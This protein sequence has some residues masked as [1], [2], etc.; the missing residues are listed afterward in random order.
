MFQL[1][2]IIQSKLRHYFCRLNFQSLFFYSMPVVSV[3]QCRSHSNIVLHNMGI[4]SPAFLPSYKTLD[5]ISKAIRDSGLEFSNLIFGIDY[6]RS[7]KHQGEKTFGGNSLH[8]LDSRQKNPY[9]QVR[10]NLMNFVSQ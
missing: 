1:I 4:Q 8:C 9:Q 3:Q 2:I 5:D 10:I 7:N 6:T